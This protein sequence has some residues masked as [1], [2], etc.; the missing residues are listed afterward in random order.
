VGYLAWYIQYGFPRTSGLAGRGW[1]PVQRLAEADCS[2]VLE[3]LRASYD[4]L[5]R[6]A[7][8]T[9]VLAALRQLI[10][11]DIVSYNEV[12]ARTNQITWLSEPADALEFL[13]STEVFNRH[14]P[15]H[16]LISHYARTNDDRALK[17]SDFLTRTEFHRL[18]LYNEFYRQARV[19]HQLACVLPAPPPVVIG[20]ALNRSR[21]DFAERHRCLLQVVRPHL[22]Q[23]FQNACI[24]SVIQ[25]EMALFG[26]ALEELGRGVVVLTR[27][28]RVR[29]MSKEAELWM[30]KYFPH[31]TRVGTRLPEPLHRWVTQ[32]QALLAGAS[33]PSPRVPLVIERE[34]ACL[35]V[36]LLSGSELLLLALEE[37]PET[38]P[39]AALQQLGLTRREAEV[40]AWLARGKTNVEIGKIADMSARTV[41]KHIEH[42]FQKLGVEN[43]TAAAIRALQT[44]ERFVATCV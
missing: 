28:G 11:C 34:G 2:R 35:V 8:R 15:E 3:F 16:P 44:A 26:R 9:H 5:D 29:S 36:R 24:V 21:P 17:L 31:S 43:R 25:E 6:S 13:D 7:F 39:L 23:A 42:L 30:A 41:E 27:D 40:L 37:Q 18:G 14:I 19:E 32:Q 4:T 22:V 38:I 10:P 12:N 1:W 20:I 33:L